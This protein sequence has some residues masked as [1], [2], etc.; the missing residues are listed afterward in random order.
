M[1][2]KLDQIR[3]KGY[4]ARNKEGKLHL[5]LFRYNNSCYVKCGNCNLKVKEVTKI[6]FIYIIGYPACTQDLDLEY[7][8]S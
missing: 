7:T 8:I 4:Y 5:Y 2:L 1:S 3:Y 6:Q